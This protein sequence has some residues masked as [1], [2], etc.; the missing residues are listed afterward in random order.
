M[1]LDA[2]ELF[3]PQ[4]LA[5][6]MRHSIRL[7]ERRNVY[8]AKER[9]LGHA[10]SNHPSFLRLKSRHSDLAEA[11]RN[12]SYNPPV[13]AVVESVMAWLCDLSQTSAPRAGQAVREP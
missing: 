11:L 4:E 6:L 7:G 8:P 9:Y 1:H 13:E 2:D 3:V 5:P 10:C 12:G